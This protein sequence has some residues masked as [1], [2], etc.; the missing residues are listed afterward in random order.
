MKT[1]ILFLL[2][3][4]ISNIYGSQI[5]NIKDGFISAISN[6]CLYFTND[7]DG[8]LLNKDILN[9]NTLKPV[10]QS[11]KIG[12]RGFFWT[13]LTLKNS[14]KT[15]Q[16][17]TIY[18]SQAGINFLEVSIYKNSKLFKTHLLG[19]L[20]EQKNREV[21]S[22]YSLFNITLLKDETITI[23]S[24]INN[25]HVYN[26]SWHI[27]NSNHFTQHEN[28]K[29]FYLA[30]FGALLCLFSLYTFLL[31]KIYKQ[32]GYL[33]LSLLSISILS[34][35]YAINGIFYFL[36]FGINLDFITTLAWNASSLILLLIILFPYYFFNIKER[37]KK[38]GYLLKIFVAV[39]TVEIIATIYA[40][41]F[42][43]N[44]F[45]LHSY[46]QYTTLLI[47]FVLACIGIYMLVK[48]EIGSVYYLLGQGVFF[49]AIII[50]TLGLYGIIPY[51]PMY[52]T[53]I[54][55]FTVVDSLFLLAAQ[56]TRTKD[57]QIELEK[58]KTI[59]L[60]QSR[61]I[62]IGQAIGNITHQWKQP[63][64]AS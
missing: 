50:N 17:L 2:F 57:K 54:P 11:Y 38:I 61:F 21:L 30:F 39:L 16:N 7:K 55:I 24:K 23:V 19:D 37:Y 58:N 3:T 26:I 56:Y 49:I 34:Y 36:N 4:F 52:K 32:Y 6:D 25:Y 47:P 10:K 8:K 48:K 46:W 44:Y 18:N 22:R 13:K 14:A 1:K 12:N 9:S 45:S 42:D 35:Q 20:N 28:Y 29:V 51:M 63:Q 15:I 53:L 31:F 60:D 62:S 41:Y 59:L 33:M 27:E 40:Q 64:P 5:L 43:E